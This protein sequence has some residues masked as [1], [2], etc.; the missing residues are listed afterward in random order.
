MTQDES[1]V[2]VRRIIHDCKDK[3]LITAAIVNH[4]K[5]YCTGVEKTTAPEKSADEI[6][7]ELFCSPLT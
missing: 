2:S 3:K 4:F 1:R 7:L 6:V 5:T